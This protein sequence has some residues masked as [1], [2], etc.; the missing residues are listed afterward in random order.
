MDAQ[1][2]GAYTVMHSL[3][4]PDECFCWITQ[5]G[6]SS[7]CHYCYMRDL[8]GGMRCR[9]FA[10]DYSL[11]Y[12]I[13]ST[14]RRKMRLPVKTTQF[15]YFGR[16]FFQSF[17]QTT[18]RSVGLGPTIFGFRITSRHIQNIV[19]GVRWREWIGC[20]HGDGRGGGGIG[21][22]DVP[23]QGLTQIKGVLGWYRVVWVVV[24]M[25]KNT[26]FAWSRRISRSS[27]ASIFK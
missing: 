18:H 9:Y 17:F 27:A 3:T 1:L 8:H 4:Y 12:I 6:K 14:D 21:S 10:R 20:H 7:H 26:A 2:N 13:V 19:G 5:E 15:L 25:I 11:R 24:M 16:N 22:H 23:F